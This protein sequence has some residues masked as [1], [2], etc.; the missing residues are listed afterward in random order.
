MLTTL[1]GVVGKVF[2][3]LYARNLTDVGKVQAELEALRAQVH[4]AQVAVEAR[5]AVRAANAGAG[6]AGVP[7][8]ESDPNLRD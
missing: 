8:D 2:E 3:W 6:P 1:F 7:I 4:G 5:E